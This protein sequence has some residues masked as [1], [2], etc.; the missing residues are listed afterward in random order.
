MPFGFV[1]APATFQRLIRGCLVYLDGEQV[2]G[3]SLG[4]H[5]INLQRVLDHL[6]NADLYKIKGHKCHFAREV[7][8][9]LNTVQDQTDSR[10]NCKVA[11]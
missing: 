9:Y 1:N 11:G 8:K 5:N 4:E 2:F 7:A 10:H 6:W 3:V